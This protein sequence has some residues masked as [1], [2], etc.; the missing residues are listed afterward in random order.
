MS[1]RN[2]KIARLPRSIREE[3]NNRLEDAEESPELLDWLNALP[4][5]QEVLE[6]QF[7]GVPISKQNLSQWRLGGFQ[8]ALLRRDLA[9]DVRD[10]SELASDAD[11]SCPKTEVADQAAVVLAARLGA[12]LANW[13]GEPDERFEAKV[14]ILSSLAKT[15]VPLQREMHRSRREL[16]EF[17]TAR[18]EKEKARQKEKADKLTGRWYDAAKAPL[19]AKMFGGGTC[20]QKIANYVLEVKRG[21][22]EAELDFEPT[23][24]YGGGIPFG[25]AKHPAKPVAPSQSE[26]K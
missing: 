6:E 11:E 1:A 24:T 7:G 2:G 26:S 15:I 25:P 18:E 9:L 14:K 22:L 20:G 16:L 21:N 8:E 23:D 12:L 4:E 5:V 13:N 17:E 3:L 10:L 19:M